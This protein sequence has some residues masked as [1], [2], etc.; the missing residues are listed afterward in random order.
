MTMDYV[1][2]CYEEMEKKV[3]GF[4]GSASKLIEKSQRNTDLFG[5]YAQL[6]SDQTAMVIKCTVLVAYP[7]HNILFNVS[8]ERR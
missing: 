3:R 5:S 1:Y 7:V 8:F 4:W 6:I 2:T